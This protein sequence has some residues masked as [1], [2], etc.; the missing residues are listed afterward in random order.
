VFTGGPR[1]GITFFCVPFIDLPPTSIHDLLS[2]NKSFG[3]MGR[4]NDTDG[5]QQVELFSKRIN[6]PSMEYEHIQKTKVSFLV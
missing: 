6:T 1:N 2:N 5:V 3:R 4:V